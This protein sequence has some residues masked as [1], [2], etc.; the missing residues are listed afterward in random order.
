MR[1]YLNGGKLTVRNSL[2]HK[3]LQVDWDFTI[4]VLPAV[5][6]WVAE[7]SW[8][9]V[10]KVIPI[11]DVVLLQNKEKLFCIYIKVVFFS[12]GN[13]LISLNDTQHQSSQM[14]LGKED[15]IGNVSW[16]KVTIKNHWMFR[17]HVT[18]LQLIKAV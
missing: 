3:P 5:W 13:T 12:K 6:L 9:K 10:E 2:A 16:S 14:T 15:A 4:I 7:A 11:S 1:S 8:K 18:V 17:F